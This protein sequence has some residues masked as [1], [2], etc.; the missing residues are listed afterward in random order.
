MYRAVAKG[1]GLFLVGTAAT[2]VTVGAVLRWQQ[3]QAPAKA[4]Q[5]EPQ[6]LTATPAQVA[7][8]DAGTLRIGERVFR[9]SGVRPPARGIACGSSED[10]AAAVTE[11]LAAMVRELPVACHRRRLGK[12]R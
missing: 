1:I 10:C 8:V 5:A 2:A 9:L 4:I 6:Q 11:A 12:S 3:S 7:V